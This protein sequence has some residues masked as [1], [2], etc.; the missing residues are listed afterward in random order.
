MIAVWDYMRN[1]ALGNWAFLNSFIHKIFRVRES[2][3]W[4]SLY[5]RKWGRGRGRD[6]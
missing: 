1:V 4:I 3:L 2:G 6:S 5:S